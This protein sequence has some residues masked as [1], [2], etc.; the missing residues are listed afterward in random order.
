MVEKTF[1]TPLAQEAKKNGEIAD[2]Y[3]M[4]RT[5]GGRASEKILYVW[6]HIYDSI[7]QMVNA[8]DWWETNG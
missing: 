5:I 6:V 1:A 2:W 7:E 8:G 3:L 4:K